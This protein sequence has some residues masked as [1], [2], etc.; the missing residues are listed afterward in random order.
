M[1]IVMK[2]A[3]NNALKENG[4]EKVLLLRNLKDA[5]CNSSIAEKFFQFLKD[6]NKKELSR[7]LSMQ[8]SAL[9]RKLHE[10]QKQIDCL[11]FL[12]YRIRQNDVHK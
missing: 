2:H 1:N 5:G 10:N 3:E 6:G 4:K 11:D 8:R 12:I 9:L 7:L